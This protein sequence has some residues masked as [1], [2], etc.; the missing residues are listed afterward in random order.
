MTPTAQEEA[1]AK[2]RILVEAVP[3]DEPWAA[4]ADR[5]RRAAAPLADGAVTDAT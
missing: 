1:Q 4:I 5:L 2:A 3:G